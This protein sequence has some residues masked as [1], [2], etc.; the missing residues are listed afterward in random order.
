MQPGAC[1][2]CLPTRGA[3]P[4]SVRD[5]HF[6]KTKLNKELKKEALLEEHLQS[7]LTQPSDLHFT[8]K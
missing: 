7:P 4:I 5:Q 1:Q 8:C 3:L 2:A 6:V